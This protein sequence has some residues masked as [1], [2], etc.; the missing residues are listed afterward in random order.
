M[1]NKLF[2]QGFLITLQVTLLTMPLGAQRVEGIVVNADTK[3][4]L[5]QSVV[6]GIN[7]FNQT[8]TL[9]DGTFAI[10]VS[11]LPVVLRVNCS[12]FESREI[13]VDT[14]FVRIEL[15]P[16]S[17]RFIES[18]VVTA[19]RKE[20]A[21]FDT[22]DA[23]SVVTQE[24]M[25]IRVPRSTAD[26]L[27]GKTG[28]WMQKTNH[29][30]GSPIVRGLTGNQV[31][32]LV[33]GIRLN[34]STFRYGP[35]QY[36]NTIDIQA[37]EKIEVVRGAGSVAYG[38][39]ALGGTIN[40]IFR[41]PQYLYDKHRLSVSG[42]VKLISQDMEKSGSTGLTYHSKDF[43]IQGDV[44]F[45]DF[46]D[47]RAGGNLGF[48]RPSGYQETGINL[49]SRY[50]LGDR[51]QIS[52]VF[53]RLNQHD[54]PRY[55]QVA[56]RGYLTYS[57]D[58]QIYQLIYAKLEHTGEH[59]LLKNISFVVSHQLS[60]ETRKIQKENVNLLQVENDVV[61]TTGFSVLLQSE[62]NTE[63]R[64]VTGVEYYRD[65]VDSKAAIID[66]DSD[67]RTPV[68]GLYPDDS[69]MES[70]GVFNRHTLEHGKFIMDA[71]ARFTT[72]ILRVEDQK[73][74]NTK[75]TPGSL[76]GNASLQYKCG[77]NRIIASVSTGFR[78]PNIND[79]STLGLFDY[80]I[81]IPSPDLEP[82]KSLNVELGFKRLSKKFFLS[83]F[84]FNSWLHD[85]IERVPAQYNGSDSLNGER[86]YKKMNVSRSYITGAEAETGIRIS[87]EL[88]LIGNITWLFGENRDKHEPLRRIPP[89]N[90]SITLHYN[91]RGFTS[92]A[93]WLWAG[94]QIRL[95]AGDIDDHRIA[96]GGTPGWSILNL[97]AGYAWTHAGIYCGITNL[98]NKTYRIHGSGIDGMGRALWI[99]LHFKW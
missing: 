7:S 19:S 43:V 90:G 11:A 34:N 68:R 75:L 37:V 22:P 26:A 9:G 72:T 77:S 73:F 53:N 70:I 89:L 42:D 61:H 64:S 33:D 44:N 32:L 93:E 47:L 21:A 95:S 13:E 15:D 27:I 10:D 62:F 8:M 87:P 88:S 84:L 80:G 14:A 24:E 55:D 57:F 76:T 92:E 12:G 71:G 5:K 52:G 85:Q 98:F 25:K 96:E 54:V 29:G 18:I 79:I 1:L 65:R 56:Q 67:G 38:S 30:G 40:V 23:L 6:G 91:Q 46:G 81:E 48:E 74:G 45:K 2:A 69:K 58:P 66:T 82:E 39:D 63:W 20:R 17:V 94:E 28:V 35:N 4:P 41:M 31:L 97:Q 60:D 83:V 59:P 51:W 16:L 49:R 86:V 3:M 36:I 78:S 99:S 50:R